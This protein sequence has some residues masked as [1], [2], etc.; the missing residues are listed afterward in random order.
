VFL[1][2]SL[3]EPER[4]VASYVSQAAESDPREWLK[5]LRRAFST[6]EAACSLSRN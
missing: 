2:V 4:D 6:R 1:I 3:R 5:G